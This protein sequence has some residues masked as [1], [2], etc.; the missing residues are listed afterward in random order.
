MSGGIGS[1]DGMINL[2]A[3]VRDG[4]IVS[5]FDHAGTELGAP[6]LGKNDP[7]TGGSEILSGESNIAG[8]LLSGRPSVATIGDSIAEQ[9]CVELAYRAK[10]IVPWML[11][12]L[13][14]PWE[15]QFADNYA[16]FG[17]TLDVI[18]RD[19]LPVFKAAAK[20]KRYAKAFV[21][22]GTN[23]TNAGRALAD[24]KADYLTLFSG[25]RDAGAVPV[26]WGILPRGT[27]GAIT[28]AKKANQLLN[29]WL[30][31]QSKLGVLEFIDVTETFAD[32]STAFG[33]CIASIMYDGLLHPSDKGAALAGKVLADYYKASGVAPGIKFATQQGDK[34]DRDANPSGVAFSSANPLL[35]GGTT[36][37]TGM[38]TSGGTWSKVNRTLQ[39]GQ[40]RTDCQCVLAA[41]ATHYLY[42]DW[43]ASGA[44]SSLQLQPGDVIEGRALIEIQSGVSIKNVELALSENNGSGNFDYHCL[45]IGTPSAIPDGNHI[46]YLKT[47]QCIVRPYALS[48]N[49]SAFL[50][51]I[52]VTDAGASGT[53]IVRAFEIRKVG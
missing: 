30:F 16:V 46:L 35:Q 27:D 6:V 38:S 49:A 20:N 50:K 47:P 53:F 24:I 52:A 23:D 48:G 33:N 10:G 43:V 7:L 32:N 51:A 9:G 25:I 22:A 40:V 14:W 2:R 13:G 1:N 4:K 41:S 39:N 3:M 11:S 8:S 31:T 44:W 21:S 36:A 37:P 29:E 18:V 28:A 34:F 12:Y 45:A 42:D 26:M 15:Y 5:L 17:T 19:Q